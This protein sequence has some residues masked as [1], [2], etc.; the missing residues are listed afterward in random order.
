VNAR[1]SVSPVGRRNTQT[2]DD[3]DDDEGWAEMKAKKDK[4]QKSWKLRKGQN[5]LQ[6]LYNGV[7]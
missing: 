1:P 4:K 6:E 7:P 5:A 2:V 3:D